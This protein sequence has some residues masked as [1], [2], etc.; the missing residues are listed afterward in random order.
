M[1]IGMFTNL[2]KRRDVIAKPL[3]KAV[4]DVHYQGEQGVAACVVF[5]RWQDSEPTRVVRTV[6]PRP[7]QYLP[8][9][10]YE[11]ELPC[12]MSV[13]CKANQAFQT[14]IIDG[15]VHLKANVGKGLGIHLSEALPHTP[16][17]IG[18]AKNPLTVAEKYVS[19]HRGKSENRLFVS[20][21]G[22]PVDRAAK[23]V[24]CMHGPYRI[25]TLLKLADQHARKTD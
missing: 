6:V 4:L 13:L 22:C 21:I 12:L 18:V 5:D 20:A 19:I 8:G 7:S 2:K 14:I 16:I 1:N 24:L 25:P 23:F 10:F 3:Q 9:R 11:R 15:Y 17:V